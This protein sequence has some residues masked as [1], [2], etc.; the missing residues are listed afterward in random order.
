MIVFLLAAMLHGLA[1]AYFKNINSAL[2]W[3]GASSHIAWNLPERNNLWLNIINK[4]DIPVH[5]CDIFCILFFST[6]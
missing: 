3:I 1:Q 6:E 5:L 2:A 4:A